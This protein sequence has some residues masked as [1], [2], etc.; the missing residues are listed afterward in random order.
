[1]YVNPV[2]PGFY[3][4]PSV[5]RLDDSFYLVASSFTYFPGVPIFRSA[6]LVNWEQIGHVLDRTSQLDLSATE[7]WGSFGTFAPTLRHHDGRF[8]MITTVVDPTRMRNFF[9]TAADPSGP[10]SDPIEVDIRGIDPDIAWDDDGTCWVHFAG[11]GG[12]N[13][14]CID[15]RSGALL[16]TPEVTWSGT[17]MT[18]VEAP[19]LVRNGDYW[20]LLVAE[21]GTERGHAVSVARASTPL[22]PWEPCPANPIV[23]HRSTGKPIQ[24]TGHADLVEA[25][26]GTWW[27]VLLGVRPRGQ[28]PMFH[29]LGRETFLAPVEWTDGWPRV[30][31]LE[32][33]MPYSPPG[34]EVVVD[35]IFRDNFD[36]AELGP[37][38]VAFRRPAA[39]FASLTARYGS[40]TLDGDADGLAGVT[41]AYVARR[42]QHHEFRARARVSTGGAAEG[43]LALLMDEHSWYSVGLVDGLV[44]ATAR[45]GPLQQRIAE[46][47]A[48]DGDI[49]VF[50]EARPAEG[51]GPDLVVL[52]YEIGEERRQL[53]ELDG[54]FLSTEVCTGFV[55]RTIGMYA[56]GG[57]ASFDWFDYR[58]I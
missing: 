34:P 5:C 9:V 41:P 23:S 52:G 28:T 20:Y 53:A 19:H 13:R 39:E 22:G 56:V 43:G 48:P 24:N 25:L 54:R 33:A 2:I 21:G 12:I 38:W 57:R 42:Q 1:M 3:P 37:C 35:P 11:R 10:W 58:P 45:I 14:V 46:E 15:D 50:V 32:L 6:D 40:L 26:D 51:G 36:D 44:A 29:V 17:G 4:D 55:G 31:D 16:S 27:M 18:S 47:P 30:A 8:F 7:G 49:V